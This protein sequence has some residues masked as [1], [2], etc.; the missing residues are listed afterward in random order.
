MPPRM[1][2]Y[3]KV[4]M[5]DVSRTSVGQDIFRI[6]L[7]KAFIDLTSS[8]NYFV[9]DDAYRRELDTSADIQRTEGDGFTRRRNVERESALA[10]LTRYEAKK[11]IPHMR[12]NWSEDVEK[13]PE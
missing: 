13:K 3:I 12:A 2:E 6:R 7:M 10:K 1:D 8:L 9:P 4:N 5:R 11:K